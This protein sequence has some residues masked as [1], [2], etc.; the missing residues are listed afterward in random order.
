MFYVYWVAPGGYT[1]FLILKHFLSTCTLNTGFQ[2]VTPLE[3]KTIYFLVLYCLNNPLHIKAQKQYKHIY[4]LLYLITYLYLYMQTTSNTPH[5]IRSMKML[6]NSHAHHGT[7]KKSKHVYYKTYR[8]AKFVAITW[9]QVPWTYWLIWK[10]CYLLL[11]SSSGVGNVVA[12]TVV[13][14]VC[15]VVD[16][17]VVTAAGNVVDGGK[18]DKGGGMVLTVMKDQVNCNYKISKIS[19]LWG[20]MWLS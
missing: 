8:V 20:I 15:V 10:R 9:L 1:I 13:A 16:R 2:N 12:T 19:I 4:L 14:G 7:E 17:S 5:N 18:V 6:S 11:L 3:K